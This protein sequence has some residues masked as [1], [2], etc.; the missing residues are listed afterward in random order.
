MVKNAVSDPKYT[1]FVAEKTKKMA[2]IAVYKDEKPISSL[3]KLN[4]GAWGG[5]CRSNP[6]ITYSEVKWT[7]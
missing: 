7:S 3:F 4:Q 2:K 5:G 1:R 6:L